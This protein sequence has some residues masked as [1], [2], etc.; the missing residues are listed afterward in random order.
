MK[1]A[2][3]NLLKDA[4]VRKPKQLLFDTSYSHKTLH[5]WL[6]TF[7]PEW[8]IIIPDDNEELEKLIRSENDARLDQKFKLVSITAC[9]K[10]I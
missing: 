5:D 8:K 2:L 1:R 6:K 7:L 3:D 9:K 10:E 4:L